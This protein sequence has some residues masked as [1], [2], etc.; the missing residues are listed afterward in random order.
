M[1][2]NLKRHD[3]CNHEAA[4]VVSNKAMRAVSTYSYPRVVATVSRDYLNRPRSCLK[5]KDNEV[6]KFVSDDDKQQQDKN[7]VT[8]L[9]QWKK[10]KMTNDRTL[11]Y[12]TARSVIYERIFIV[13]KKTKLKVADNS[14]QFVDITDPKLLQRWVTNNENHR[15]TFE[16]LYK[17]FEDATDSNSKRWSIEAETMKRSGFQY[18]SSDDI[19]QTAPAG[20]RHVTGGGTVFLVSLAL[21]DIRKHANYYRKKLGKP[22]LS[23]LVKTSNKDK[24]KKRRKY[25]EFDISLVV[26]PT[27]SGTQPGD[28]DL[29]YIPVRICVC[30]CLSFRRTK[31]SLTFL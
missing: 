31:N 15:L 2:S 21:S 28:S 25:G 20:C 23:A 16:I 26:Y 29:S 30:I 1:I 3:S 18:T 22:I 24:N 9:L 19:R 6:F 27:P 5:F 10:A 14:G 11:V 7:D 17:P 8:D 4:D 12:N 13:S